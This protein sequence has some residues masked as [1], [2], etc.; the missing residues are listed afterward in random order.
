MSS[1]NLSSRHAKCRSCPASI[2]WAVSATTG[3]KMPVD[4]SPD[5]AKGNVLLQLDRG[6][7]VAAVLTGPRLAGARDAGAELR[8]AHHTTCPNADLHRRRR[9][10]ARTGDTRP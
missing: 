4:Y 8:T 3:S 1:L 7:L 10:T 2:V 6:Q 5:A 9:T